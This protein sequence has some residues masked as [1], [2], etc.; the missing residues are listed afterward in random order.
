MKKFLKLLCIAVLLLQNTYAAEKIDEKK[1]GKAFADNVVPGIVEMENFNNGENGV[2]YLDGTESKATVYR[3]DTDVEIYAYAKNYMVAPYTG[4][5]LNYTVNAL[6]EGR[7]VISVFGYDGTGNGGGVTIYVNGKKVL[8]NA[9]VSPTVNN[10]FSEQELGVIEL[11]KGLNVIKFEMSKGYGGYDYMRLLRKRDSGAAKTAYFAR[12]VPCMIMAQNYDTSGEEISYHTEKFESSAKNSRNDN[13]NLMSDQNGKYILLKENDWI[14]YTVRNGDFTEYDILLTAQGKDNDISILRD[15]RE[16]IRGSVETDGKDTVRFGTV[17]VS[18]AE[19]T[20][21]IKVNSGEV[22][23]Y[24]VK[25]DVTNIGESTKKFIRISDNDDKNDKPALAP[26]TVEK[27]IYVSP[28]GTGD[29]TAENPASLEK[30]INIFETSKDKMTG[31]VKILLADG[32]YNVAKTLKLDEK[33][34]GNNN[35]NLIIEA[36]NAGGAVINGA[37]QSVKW[38]EDANG[39]MSAETTEKIS[40]L[41]DGGKLKPVAK[42][43]TIKAVSGTGNEITIAGKKEFANDKNLAAVWN[44]GHRYIRIGI[45]TVRY[46]DEKTIVV[47]NAEQY[48]KAADM[49]GKEYTPSWDKPFYIENDVSLSDNGTWCYVDEEKRVYYKPEKGKNAEDVKLCATDKALIEICETKNVIFRGIKFV[50]GDGATSFA[51]SEA[52]CDLYSEEKLPAAIQM[53]N[54]QN[55]VFDKNI[56]EGFAATAIDVGENCGNIKITENTFDNIGGSAVSTGVSNIKTAGDLGRIPENVTISGNSIKNTGM[57]V[58]SAPAL[59][60]YNSDN[61]YVEKNNI[62]NTPYAGIYVGQNRGNTANVCRNLYIRDNVLENTMTEL[63]NGGAVALCGKYTNVTVEN[64]ALKGN[65]IYFGTYANGY[66]IKNNTVDT[67]GLW[68]NIW[69]PE[70][71]DIVIIKNEATGNSVLKGSNITVID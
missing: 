11:E 40:G 12:K 41:I 42:S 1:Y 49:T 65:G 5:W 48:K 62:S 16:V 71:T 7:Y 38:E 67:D 14:N 30:A 66:I 17:G 53:K 68:I 33:V 29:G 32:V 4:E 57:Y 24:A 52:D 26:E 35:Y 18:S 59:M 31:N 63:E 61:T 39:I 8:D 27:T 37:V 44:T 34:S 70:V 69:S 50:G 64:N 15:G 28:D 23:L 47:L 3:K 2:A 51:S 58:K 6:A 9:V 22:K 10:A 20:Y 43:E 56:F 46:E 21:S 13:V 45:D 19:S 55:I 60:L 36:E 25:F 54:C